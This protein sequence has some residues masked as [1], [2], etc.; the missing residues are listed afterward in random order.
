VGLKDCHEALQIW[1]STS[2]DAIGC[3]M[4]IAIFKSRDLKFKERQVAKTLTDTEITEQ[5]SLGEMLMS[6]KHAGEVKEGVKTSTEACGYL[7]TF[8][9]RKITAFFMNDHGDAN[10]IWSSQVPSFCGAM[11]NM[12][13][14][15]SRGELRILPSSSHRTDE[16]V[17][18]CLHFTG[19]PCYLDV[20]A[21]VRPI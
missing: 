6:H 17:T 11:V 13:P 19:H 14:R 8:L 4:V 9:S 7:L 18:C 21:S 12:A 1:V 16:V 3:R 5:F 15:T 20:L 2:S 10:C